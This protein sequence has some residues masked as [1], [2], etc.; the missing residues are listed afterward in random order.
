[1]SGKR[2]WR[3]GVRASL[4]SQRSVSEALPSAVVSVEGVQCRPLVGCSR[5]IAPVSCCRTWKK[6]AVKIVTVGGEEWQ[7]KGKGS[8]RLQPS[9]G[10]STIMSVNVTPSIPLGFTFI[11]SMDGIK[12]LGGVKIDSQCGVRFGADE[13]LTCAAVEEVDEPNFTASYNP[14]TNSWTAA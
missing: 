10:V 2:V 1:M 9:S 3:G 14:V 6:E 7:C 5:S 13:T 8:V 11:L 12:A 4:F